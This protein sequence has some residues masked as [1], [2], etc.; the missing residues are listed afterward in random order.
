VADPEAIRALLCNQTAQ[1]REATL[2]ALAAQSELHTDW[3]EPLVRRPLLSARAQRMLAEIVTGHLLEK[4]AARADLDPK[5]GDAL[6]AAMRA[7]TPV[8]ASSSRS[9]GTTKAE[10][11]PR[12]ALAQ[13]ETLKQSGCLDDY[14]V[15]NALRTNEMIAAKAMLA[16]KAGVALRV[17]ERACDLRSAKAIVSLAWKAGLSPQ[18]A[19]VLQTMLGYLPAAQTLRPGKVDGFPL[20]EDEMRWQLT[21]LGAPEIDTRTWMPRQL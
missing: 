2:D 19:V 14:A 20:S 12:I 21:F 8:G 16:V 6:R 1:I 3:Q 4:L 5:V 10:L 13:A 17:V 11:D 7:Q 18:T 9:G 15:V